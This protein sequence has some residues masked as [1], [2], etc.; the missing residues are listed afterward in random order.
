MDRIQNRDKRDF[1]SILGRKGVPLSYVIRNNKDRPVITPGSTR[2]DKIYWKAP[3][4]GAA[5]DADNLRV[6]TYL[7]HRCS[8]TPGWIRIQQYRATNNGR[9]ASLVLC[10]NHG[11]ENIVPPDEPSYEDNN[12]AYINHRNPEYHDI[13]DRWHHARRSGHAPMSSEMMDLE[14]VFYTASNYRGNIHGFDMNPRIICPEKTR[15]LARRP[16]FQ[17]T[18]HPKHRKFCCV[19]QKS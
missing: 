17:R 15:K 3:I 19:S 18:K 9:N 11:V 5:F 2:C 1:T 16:F 8:D 7:L 14:M 10:H 13:Y 4:V 6:W 12:Y